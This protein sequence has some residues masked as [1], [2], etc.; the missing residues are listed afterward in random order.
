MM[1]VRNGQEEIVRGL[2][3]RGADPLRMNSKG[4]SAID[5]A[6]AASGGK[7]QAATVAAMLAQA[8]QLARDARFLQSC[9]GMPARR[10]LH[11]KPCAPKFILHR[12]QTDSPD[13]PTRAQTPPLSP[14]APP[15]GLSIS[16][17]Y[18]RDISIC[19]LAHQDLA[20][21]GFKFLT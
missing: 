2:L 17:R 10:H 21:V 13:T 1:A 8:P 6:V 3:K 12:P 11:L 18:A 16:Q 15:A 4:E 7:C 9:L 14:D 20:A 5:L 19:T